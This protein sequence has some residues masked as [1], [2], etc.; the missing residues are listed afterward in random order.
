[1]IRTAIGGFLHSPPN[2][3]YDDNC[4]SFALREKSSQKA[5]SRLDFRGFC[6]ISIQTEDPMIL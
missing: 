4:M 2:R 1:M 6:Q 5:E 3:F